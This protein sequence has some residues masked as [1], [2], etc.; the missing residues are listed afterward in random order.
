[1]GE[2]INGLYKRFSDA[3]Y[4]HTDSAKKKVLKYGWDNGW[5]GCTGDKT[6]ID[7]QCFPFRRWAFISDLSLPIIG[8]VNIWSNYGDSSGYISCGKYR[9]LRI[10]LDNIILPII[11]KS[12]E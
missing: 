1:M 12:L 6:F 11:Y 7:R 9:M 2:D 4:V 8:N 10:A 5:S 3:L